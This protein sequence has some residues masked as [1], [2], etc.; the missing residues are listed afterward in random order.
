M[1]RREKQNKTTS[2]SPQK[3]RSCPCLNLENEATAQKEKH[4]KI[5][6]ITIM[7]KYINWRQKP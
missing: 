1:E 3:H 7:E 4:S 6:L 2:M 5:C